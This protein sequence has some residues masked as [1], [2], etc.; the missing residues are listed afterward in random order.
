MKKFVIL[1]VSA[2]MLGAGV[3]AGVALADPNPTLTTT[4]HRHFI[5]GSEVGPR[6]CDNAN[7]LGSFTQFHANIHSHTGVTGEIGDPAPGIA[8]SGPSQNT[9]TSGPC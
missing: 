3:V 5:N 7:L 9:I 1:A 2:A 6:Y 8:A 4:A